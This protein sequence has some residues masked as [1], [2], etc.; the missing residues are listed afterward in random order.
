M[1]GLALLCARHL[2][3]AKQAK[4]SLPLF[5]GGV[6]AGYE[7]RCLGMKC[8]DPALDIVHFLLSDLQSDGIGKYDSLSPPPNQFLRN[9]AT[10][11]P[12]GARST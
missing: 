10:C 7:W 11:S 12:N 9:I 5:G 2:P 4:G 1:L 3:V 6:G 8:P